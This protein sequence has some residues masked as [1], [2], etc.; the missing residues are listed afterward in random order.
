MPANSLSAE[1]LNN[2]FPD[3]G[4]LAVFPA[5]TLD[6]KTQGAAMGLAASYNLTRKPGASAAAF[7]GSTL[8]ID[9]LGYYQA[10]VTMGTTVRTFLIACFP[11]G[12]VARGYTLTG[13]NRLIRESNCTTTTLAAVL[14]TGATNPVINGAILGNPLCFNQTQFAT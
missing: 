5:T 2:A 1:L 13:L 11:T 12:A 3:D 8:T 14:E 6:F 9:A 7:S 4:M 10:T